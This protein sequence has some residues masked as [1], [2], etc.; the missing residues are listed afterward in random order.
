MASKS[1][2][3]L[4][5]AEKVRVRRKWHWGTFGHFVTVLFTLIITVVVIVVMVCGQFFLGPSQAASDAMVQTLHQSS[6]LKFVPYLYLYEHVSEALT[7]SEVV[8][9]EEVTDTSLITVKARTPKNYD[10]ADEIEEFD[11]NGLRLEEVKGATYHGYMLIV[12]DPSRV[13]VG[14]SSKGF[15][16]SKPGKYVDE[17]M[18]SYNALAGMNAGA[19]SDSGGSGNGGTPMGMVYSEGKRYCGYNSD[20]KVMAGF[21][22]NDILHVGAFTTAQCDEMGIRDASAFGPA[23]IVNGVPSVAEDK[24]LNPRTAIGQRA[25]GAV[26]MLVIDG[27]QAN[28]LGATIADLINIMSDY[29]AINAC[30]MD[31]GSSTCMYMYGKKINDGMTISVGRHLPTAWIVK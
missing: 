21:D 1:E 10:A 5:R 3:R 11:E 29:G 20:Y 12:E 13:T 28:S 24:G 6:A 30:N 7:R 9:N 25:D 2:K 18:A 4:E 27:R 15:S 31:G 8:S 19:F 23:L 22:E 17:I 16:S 14:V 26:L